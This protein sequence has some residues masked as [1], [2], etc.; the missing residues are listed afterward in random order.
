[1]LRQKNNAILIYV[2]SFGTQSSTFVVNK[3]DKIMV[4]IKIKSLVITGLLALPML[5]WAQTETTQMKSSNNQQKMENKVVI[6]KVIV[7]QSSLEEFRQQNVTGGFLKTLPGFLNG[8]TY[9]KLDDSGNLTLISVTTWLNQESYENAEKSL[10]EFYK[11]I[12]FNP[13]MYRER[14]KITAE[15]AVYAKH[16][17]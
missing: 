16:D 8:A 2:N 9:E 13:M 11:S 1:M 3:S 4:F 14:L 12:N 17:F 5:S 7:P 6:G 15:H 10:K